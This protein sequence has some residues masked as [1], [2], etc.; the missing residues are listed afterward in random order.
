[1]IQ[2]IFRSIFLIRREAKL[3]LMIGI[4]ITLKKLSITIN[5]QKN[6]ELRNRAKGTV[7]SNQSKNSREKYQRWLDRVMR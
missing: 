1:M 2:K 5:S 4:W 7:R 6:R 3:I